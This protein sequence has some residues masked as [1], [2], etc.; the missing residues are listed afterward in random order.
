MAAI[1]CLFSVALCKIS[2]QGV[3][4]NPSSLQYDN[5]FKHDSVSILPLSVQIITVPRA[6]ISP[7]PEIY[8]YVHINGKEWFGLVVIP[9]PAARG[10]PSRLKVQLSIGFRLTSVSLPKEIIS[11]F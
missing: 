6:Y 5:E 1:Y 4:E 7:C 2:S 8:R 9:N 11:K 10:I 3:M